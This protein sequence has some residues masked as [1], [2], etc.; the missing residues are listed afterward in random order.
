MTNASSS[1][2]LSVYWC[3]NWCNNILVDL[4]QT[5][6][7]TTEKQ[8]KVIKKIKDLEVLYLTV[9]KKIERLDKQHDKTSRSILDMEERFE[10]ERIKI[11]KTNKL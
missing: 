9:L 4:L 5:K 3:H 10:K 8:D 7:K 2:Y 6:K 11:W 1:T